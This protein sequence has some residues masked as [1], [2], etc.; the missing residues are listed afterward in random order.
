MVG[1][2]RPNFYFDTVQISEHKIQ[3]VRATGGPTDE[4]PKTVVRGDVLQLLSQG[5]V[6]TGMF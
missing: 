5:R 6:A 2:L 3:S 4:L 1:N